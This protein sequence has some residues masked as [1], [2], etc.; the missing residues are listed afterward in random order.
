MIFTW[1]IQK[2][3]LGLGHRPNTNKK[4]MFRW[5]RKPLGLYQP[6][7]ESSLFSGLQKPQS[8][9]NFEELLKTNVSSQ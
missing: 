5:K 1:R 8:P 4:G 6:K 9:N 7:S 3:A 2:S